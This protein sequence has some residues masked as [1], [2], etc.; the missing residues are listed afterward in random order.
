MDSTVYIGA[1]RLLPF[2]QPEGF[3]V[4]VAA[5]A[6]LTDAPPLAEEA[7]EAA[8]CVTSTVVE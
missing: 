6:A 8:A 4:P 2:E 5:E 1:Q 3:P 7:G